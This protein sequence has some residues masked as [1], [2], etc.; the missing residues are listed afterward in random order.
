MKWLI[1][2][3]FLSSCSPSE[4]SKIYSKFE[5]ANIVKAVASKSLVNCGNSSGTILFLGKDK[6]FNERLDGVEV[7]Q[8]QYICDNPEKDINRSGY[9]ILFRVVHSN[10]I[11]RCE[12]SGMLIIEGKDYTRNNK[13]DLAELRIVT[14]LCNDCCKKS[15]REA[16]QVL[17]IVDPCGDGKGEDEV[18]VKLENGAFISHFKS[19]YKSFTTLKAEVV[20]ETVDNQKCKF[21]IEGGE[22]L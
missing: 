13:L 11:P 9:N 17:E 7:K 14:Y 4:Y 12:S 10:Y 6:N 20:Y 21:K 3:I 16:F 15:N 19:E 8:M 22:I 1:I 18:L 2:A 5:D